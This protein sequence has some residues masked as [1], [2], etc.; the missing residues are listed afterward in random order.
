MKSGIAHSARREL[1]LV[2]ALATGG[3]ALVVAV[4]FAPWYEP[5]VAGNSGN[6]TVVHTYPA[7]AA[8]LTAADAR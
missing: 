1:A 5:V 4:A 3:V 6:V 7:V 8:D 2:I